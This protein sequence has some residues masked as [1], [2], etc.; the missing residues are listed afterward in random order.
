MVMSCFPY[1]NSHLQQSHV[2]SLSSTVGVDGNFV[3]VAIDSLQ[4]FTLQSYK[5]VITKGR[6]QNTRPLFERPGVNLGCGADRNRT[7]NP[8]GCDVTALF[9]PHYTAVACVKGAEGNL[10][11]LG[12][13]E[14]LAVSEKDFSGG[15]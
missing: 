4:L 11:T 8:L 1:E 15:S 12:G 5:P 14:S 2:A 7:G 13:G 10:R 6:T 9:N 3:I